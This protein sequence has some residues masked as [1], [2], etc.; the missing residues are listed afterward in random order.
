MQLQLCVLQIVKMKLQ[1]VSIKQ[2]YVGCTQ[3]LR[4]YSFLFIRI[5]QLQHFFT[6]KKDENIGKDR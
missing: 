6:Q 2:A 4:T 5:E 3:R 1:S